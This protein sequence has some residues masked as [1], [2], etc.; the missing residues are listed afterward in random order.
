MNSKDNR[1]EKLKCELTC[2]L[3]SNFKEITR[4]VKILSN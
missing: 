3:F 4:A 2:L 1:C